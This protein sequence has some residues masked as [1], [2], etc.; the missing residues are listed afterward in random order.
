MHTRTR[1][2]RLAAISALTLTIGAGAAAGPASASYQSSAGSAPI[3]TLATGDD[4]LT[5][6]G[7][8]FP[9]AIDT[10]SAGEDASTDGIGRGGGIHS[11]E[12]RAGADSD[13]TP[14]FTWSAEDDATPTGSISSI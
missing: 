8:P 13:D 11:V 12:D 14:S 5:G 10:M 4:S 6:G 9:T 7:N 1:I 3:D 2:A